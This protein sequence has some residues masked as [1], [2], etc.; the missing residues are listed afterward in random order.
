M[1]RQITA[2][3]QHDDEI[4]IFY[5]P[6]LTILII[7]ACIKN[8]QFIYSGGFMLLCQPS[9]S[10]LSHLGTLSLFEYCSAYFRQINVSMLMLVTGERKPT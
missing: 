1:N 10:G 6:L 7:D 2:L 3:A 5:F 9:P 4:T 8:L